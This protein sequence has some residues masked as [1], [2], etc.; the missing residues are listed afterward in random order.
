[1]KTRNQQWYTACKE[2]YGLRVTAL[3]NNNYNIEEH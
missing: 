1:M 2:I 3:H